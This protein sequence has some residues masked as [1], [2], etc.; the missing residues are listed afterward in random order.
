MATFWALSNSVPRLQA[1]DD[2]RALWIATAA[3]SSEGMKELDE[4]L[5][6]TVGETI[7]MSPVVSAKRDEGGFDQLKAIAMGGF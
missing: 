6:R 4:S 2:R 1:D 3:Q 7:T 5:L